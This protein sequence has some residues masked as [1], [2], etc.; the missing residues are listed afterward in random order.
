MDTGIHYIGSLDEG[1]IMNQYFR[2][3]GIMD[4][5]SIKRMD[6]EGFDRIYYKDAIYDYAIGY[7]RF[8]ETLCC[9]SL[10]HISPNE[11]PYDEPKGKEFSVIVLNADFEIIL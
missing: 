9:L 3:F 4:K 10:I 6:E 1:Q 7:E 11:S 8:M 2:Y 5:L